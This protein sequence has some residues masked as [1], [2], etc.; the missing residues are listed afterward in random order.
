MPTWLEGDDWSRMFRDF[1]QSVFR[2]ETRDLY[3]MP[4]EEDEFRRF[5]EGEKPPADLWYPWLDTVVQAVQAGKSVQ[6]VHVV[7]S[8]LSSYIRYEAEWGYVFNIQVGEDIRILDLATTPDP[9]LPEQDFFLFDDT[10]VVL[11]HY[12]DDGT[13]IGRELLDAPDIARYVE[14]KR[15][16]LETSTPFVDYYQA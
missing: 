5:L 3:T 16:A 10:N 9:G 4:D 11:M 6:R 2:L 7:T 15:M 12:R 8:P 13:Q 14:W 1:R